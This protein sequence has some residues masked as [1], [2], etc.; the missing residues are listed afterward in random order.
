[1]LGLVSSSMM[2]GAAFK[3]T[4]SNRPQSEGFSR[5][6]LPMCY[7]AGH[8]ATHWL[9]FPCCLCAPLL[10]DVTESAIYVAITGPYQ[11]FWVA[12]CAQG[13]CKYFGDYADFIHAINYSR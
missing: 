5:G 8:R 13:L 4:D 11:G 9:I 7:F 12:S 10:G 6:R 1:M 2:Q 3:L